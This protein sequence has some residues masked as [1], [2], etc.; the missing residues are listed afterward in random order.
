[1]RL[2]RKEVEKGLFLQRELRQRQQQLQQQ[3]EEQ[4][5]KGKGKG[6]GKKNYRHHEEEEWLPGRGKVVCELGPQELNKYEHLCITVF[7]FRFLILFSCT[8]FLY[9]C[10]TFYS[11]FY[12]TLYST[13]YTTIYTTVYRVSFANVLVKLSLS[14]VCV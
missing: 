5:E 14:F 7:I 3:K 8:I 13:F 2:A 1:M 11:T 12:S 6:K 9:C 10:S 4:K